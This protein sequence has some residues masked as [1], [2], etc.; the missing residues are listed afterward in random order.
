[1]SVPEKEQKLK[2]LLAAHKDMIY[3]LCY[4]YLY[5]KEDIEDLFQEITINIWNHLDQFR[6]ASKISTWIYRIVVN[7]A[8]LYN[9]KDKKLKTVFSNIDM[10][11][12]IAPMDESDEYLEKEKRIEQL[13]VAINQLKKQD[14]L[15]ISLV[16]E[17][18]KYEEIAEIMGMTMSYVGVKINRI[19]TTLF[20]LLQ[21]N[22]NG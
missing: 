19:K 7:S 21:E 20:N 6:G 4:A 13:N 11:P 2:E 10:E 17:G 12:P 5:N 9:K 1:M 15:I 14:R 22:S 8:L 3:R 16:L 18:V